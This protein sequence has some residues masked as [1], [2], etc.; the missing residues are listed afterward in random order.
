MGSASENGTEVVVGTAVMRI[1]QN[2]RNVATAVAD[3][4][5]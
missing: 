2:S 5:K 1:G 4:L 3:R